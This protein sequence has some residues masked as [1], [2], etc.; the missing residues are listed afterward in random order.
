VL[1][2][3]TECAKPGTRSKLRRG[4][5]KDVDEVPSMHEIVAPWLPEH[6][7]RESERAYY[8]VASMIADRPRHSSDSSS[9]DAEPPESTV[10]RSENEPDEKTAS[11]YGV[12]LGA[13][14]AQA[15]F[16]A[17]PHERERRIAGTRRRLDILVRQSTSGLHRYL[18]SSVRF[19]RQCEVEPD[20]AQLLT[21]LT[22]WPDYAGDIGRR[23]QQ[24][25]FRLLHKADWD[26][27][28]RDDFAVSLR[29][30]VSPDS[31]TGD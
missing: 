26:R 6:R 8:A 27:A 25:Y 2:I 11:P 15:V 24:D 12:S 30:A 18:P 1:E 20:W 19:L 21:D 31:P 7:S 10:A 28:D 3:K 29:G 23:W 22:F 13:T 4:L 5:G 14:L 16:A 9:R 17:A